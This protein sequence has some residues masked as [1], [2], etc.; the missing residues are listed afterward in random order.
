ML[1][2]ALGLQLRRLL[3]DSA[4]RHFFQHV[5]VDALCSEI[6]DWT[7][8]QIPSGATDLDQLICGGMTLRGSVEPPPVV[9]WTLEI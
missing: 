2:A 9:T 4:S 3:S 7:I 6:R 5:D 1:K 8:P